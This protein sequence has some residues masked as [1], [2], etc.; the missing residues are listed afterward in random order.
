MLGVRSNFNSTKKGLLKENVSYPE[1]EQGTET[2]TERRR[3]I[4]R[5]RGRVRLLLA[6]WARNLENLG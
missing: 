6:Y 3:Y 5:C 2:K 4:P 1:S